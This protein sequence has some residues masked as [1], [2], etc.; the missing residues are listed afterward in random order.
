MRGGIKFMADEPFTRDLF[1]ELAA[2]YAKLGAVEFDEV[3]DRQL[4]EDINLV[5][6]H[7]GVGKDFL[8]RC[9]LGSTESDPYS[10]LR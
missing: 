9:E 7:T 10:G 8:I 2:V 4:L 6:H 5:K 1:D 3:S